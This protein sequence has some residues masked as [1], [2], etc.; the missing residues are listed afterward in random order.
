M[1][2]SKTVKKR[3]LSIIDEMDKVHWLFTK[4]PASDFSRTKKWSFSEMMKFI[5][6]MEGKA[7]K[8]ELL[9]YFDFS[10]NT[11]S[12]ASFNQRRAQILPEAFEF[13][14]NEF[15]HAVSKP[16]LYQ[17]YRLLACDGSDLNIAHNP[18]DEA[19]Y[20]QSLADSKGF[21]QIHLN[22]LYDLRTKT[23]IDAII[24]PS[25]KENEY[26]A[27]CDMVDRYDSENKT[28]FIADR[29][30][31]NYNIFAHISEKHQ[32]YLIR[33]KDLYSNGIVASAKTLLPKSKESFDETISITLTRKQTK[34]V[35]AA[36]EK[37]RIIMKVTPFDYLDLYDNKFYKMN[38]RIVRFPISE[39]SYECIITNLPETEFPSEK[40]KELYHMRW[41]IMLI[42]A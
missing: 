27:M 20:F 23:Y 36:P 4:N 19:T 41:G 9:E 5:M 33:V 26:K 14:F 31:E 25:R 37:Y 10:K 15:T 28:I 24:Q 7:L 38:M 22:A 1:S 12:S 8:D 35:K 40:I 2:H 17:G 32:F 21:N 18:N 39:N 29:G 3:L 11:P 34:E 16:K 30:Y 6:A 13:L 42:S